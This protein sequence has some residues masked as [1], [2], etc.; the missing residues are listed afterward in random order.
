MAA[1]NLDPVFAALGR[2]TAWLGPAGNG[3]VAA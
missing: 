2:T 1:E 3:F